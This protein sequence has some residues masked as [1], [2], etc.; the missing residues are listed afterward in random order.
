[1][2][3]LQSGQEPRRNARILPVYAGKKEFKIALRNFPQA[4][5]RLKQKPPPG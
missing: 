2:L 5:S 4:I 1:M 3:W